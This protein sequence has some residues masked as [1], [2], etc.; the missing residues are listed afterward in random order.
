[1]PVTYEVLSRDHEGTTR[2]E[3]RFGDEL[4][5]EGEFPGRG[6]DRAARMA[7]ALRQRGDIEHAWWV[8]HGSGEFVPCRTG[9][10]VSTCY[11]VPRCSGHPQGFGSF[12]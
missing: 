1:M 11:H 2:L 12:R 4:F 7:E 3:D 5:T 10:R 9:D 8:R 6:E